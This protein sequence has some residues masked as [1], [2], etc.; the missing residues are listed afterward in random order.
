M[1]CKI[2]IRATAGEGLEIAAAVSGLA[3]ADVVLQGADE[4]GAVDLRESAVGIAGAAHW[5][6]GAGADVVVLAGADAQEVGPH[7]AERCPDAVVVVAGAPV[8]QTCRDLLTT[9]R[10]PRAR[11]IGVAG[12][13]EAVRLRA[14]V[15]HA[16]GVSAHDVSALV[17]GGRGASAVPVLSALRLGGM[18]VTD[19]LAADQ[20]AGLVTGIHD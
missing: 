2:V 20:V 19:K 4:A 11:V 3:G 13:V 5:N 16:L 9:T 17:L 6:A 10:F 12:I 14:E 15:A 1:S 7:V 8:E 18:R